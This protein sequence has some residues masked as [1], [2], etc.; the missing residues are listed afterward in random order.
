VPGLL[1]RRLL[2]LAIVPATASWCMSYKQLAVEC[3]CAPGVS[4]ASILR[5]ASIM[6]E[7]SRNACLLTV[8][9]DVE[10]VIRAVSNTCGNV[11]D[12][13]AGL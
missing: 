12:H 9:A 13:V 8:L 3:G 6:Q 2:I 4:P 7:M 1:R 11:G 5:H 10:G